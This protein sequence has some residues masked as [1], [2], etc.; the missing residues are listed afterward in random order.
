MTL[1]RIIGLAGALGVLGA[2]LG[3][4]I[5]TVILGPGYG[6]AVAVVTAIV[7]ALLAWALIAS[8]PE[9]AATPPPASEATAQERPNRPGR[10]SKVMVTRSGP[11]RAA[12]AGGEQARRK[13]R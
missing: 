8:R 6:V 5:G 7:F 4:M 1:R 10:Q 9:R 2:V 3:W 13:E 12:R 11:E